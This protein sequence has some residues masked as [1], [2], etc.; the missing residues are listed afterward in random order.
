MLCGRGVR[1]VLFHYRDKK[2]HKKNTRGSY[3]ATRASIPPPHRLHVRFSFIWPDPF[4]LNVNAAINL[5]SRTDTQVM[6]AMN[7][8]PE[9]IEEPAKELNNTAGHG[10]TTC[11]HDLPDGT[12][13]FPETDFETILGLSPWYG[14]R[15]VLYFCCKC[16]MGPQ[17][18]Q[19]NPCCSHCHALRCWRCTQFSTD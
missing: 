9:A 10:E 12:D 18:S 4:L 2:S 3:S 13:Q 8:P 6:A 5:C 7:S 15:S 17:V 11:E 16:F 1:I 19:I 14:S